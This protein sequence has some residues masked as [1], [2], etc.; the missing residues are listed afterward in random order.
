LEKIALKDVLDCLR[1][2]PE[3]S[4]KL[5]D[6]TLSEPAIDELLQGLGAAYEPVL[7]DKTLRDVLEQSA[8]S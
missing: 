7:G 8:D 1:S 6:R 5:D 4:L 2:A 3:E